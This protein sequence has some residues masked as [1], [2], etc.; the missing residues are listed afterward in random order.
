M[1][2]EVDALIKAKKIPFFVRKLAMAK[3]ELYAAEKGLANVT[4]EAVEEAKKAIFRKTGTD[5]KELL[6]LMKDVPVPLAAPRPPGSI[7]GDQGLGVA[8]RWRMER[9]IV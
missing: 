8:A 1:K 2:W 3:I 7:G 9:R 6:R 4:V 5:T